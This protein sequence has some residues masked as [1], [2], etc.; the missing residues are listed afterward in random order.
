[1]GIV[2]PLL[3]TYIRF[4]MFRIFIGSETAV[5]GGK[6]PLYMAES[7]PRILSYKQYRSRLLMAKPR[8]HKG[9]IIPA[10]ALSR[11]NYQGINIPKDL[12]INRE[13]L[14]LI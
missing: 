6:I 4:S 7:E 10:L 2:E 11:E 12:P 5:F 14:P 13:S 3:P 9:S 8:L 1:V